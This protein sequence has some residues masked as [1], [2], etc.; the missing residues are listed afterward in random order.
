MDDINVISFSKMNKEVLNQYDSECKLI[1]NL[2]Y[3]LCITEGK[4]NTVHSIDCYKQ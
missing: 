3:F 2:I 4:T 1:K